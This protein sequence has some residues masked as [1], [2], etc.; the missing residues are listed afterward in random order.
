[1]SA[2]GSKSKLLAATKELS[3]KWQDT[4]TYWRDEKATEFE[5]QYL[6][7]LFTNID[8]AVAVMEKLDELLTKIRKDC[9]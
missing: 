9:E 1:M 2:T 3:L 7:E 6:M 8:K 5:R 4:K